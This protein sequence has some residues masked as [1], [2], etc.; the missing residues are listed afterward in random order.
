[1]RKTLTL[2]TTRLPAARD[3]IRIDQLIDRLQT[4][5]PSGQIHS[6]RR[7]FPP[8]LS[9]TRI[10]KMFPGRLEA[11]MMKPSMYTV[12][13][14]EQRGW[15]SWCIYYCLIQL[16]EQKHNKQKEKVSKDENF[17]QHIWSFLAL[18][19]WSTTEQ[20]NRSIISTGCLLKCVFTA[21]ERMF[22]TVL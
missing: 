2:E 21:C 8:V 22:G 10:V 7:T 6:H 20:L 3:T 1:M 5:S 14:E 17:K 13:T 9:I 18:A 12:H 16:E 4:A 19:G 15:I 11:A